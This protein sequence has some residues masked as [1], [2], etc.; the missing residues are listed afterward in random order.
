MTTAQFLYLM[1]VLWLI[2]AGVVTAARKQSKG[3]DIDMIVPVIIGII[4]FGLVHIFF[5]F[6]Y[7]AIS[8]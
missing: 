8:W 4:L 3:K 5:A 6:I 1:G 2:F 7:L